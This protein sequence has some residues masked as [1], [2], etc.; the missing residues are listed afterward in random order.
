MGDSTCSQT[1]AQRTANMQANWQDN[2]IQIP[3]KTLTGL[4]TARS[5]NNPNADSLFKQAYSSP[6]RVTG[7][8]SIAVFAIDP[9]KGTLTPV[10]Y[11][12]TGGKWPRNFEIDPTGS[13]LFAANS[14]SGNIRLFRI[15]PASGRLTPTGQ[16]L[17]VPAPLCVA[18]VAIE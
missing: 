6:V 11:V 12:P 18:F 9:R 10:E 14:N 3:I 15:D 13:Y 2:E 7:H 4:K 1:T 17:E 8:D 5:R 16:V